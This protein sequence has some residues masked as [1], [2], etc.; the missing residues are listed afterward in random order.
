MTSRFRSVL[1][2]MAIALTIG[3]VAPADADAQTRPPTPPRAPRPPRPSHGWFDSDEGRVARIDTTLAFSANGSVDLS[4]MSG[5]IRV[6][7]WNRDQVRVVA[8]ATNGATLDFDASGS[9]VDLGIHNSRSDEGGSANY[10]VTVPAGARLTLSAI[11]GSIT[12][13]GVRGGIDAN[14]VS[15]PVD[16]RDAAASVAIESVS[17]SVIA[18]GVAGDVKVETVS[19]A[20]EVAN[21]SGTVSAGDVSGSIDLSNTR[22]TRVRANSV[23]GAITYAG[24]LNPAGRYELETHSGRT[25]LRLASGAS[26]VITVNTYSGSVSNDYPGVVRRP[27]SDADDERTSY[28]YTIGRGDARVSIETFSGRVQIS[29]G[30]R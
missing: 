1:A 25:I 9:H 6:S 8:T 4:L 21:V 26:A 20:I 19:G 28:K 2:C 29:Q 17:G 24:A 5:S 30:N 27:E 23:S 22:G 18:S 11:S 3:A 16:V 7:A 14:S 10:D 12:A 13:A 15:G